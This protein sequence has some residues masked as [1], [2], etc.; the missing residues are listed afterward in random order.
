MDD[1]IYIYL[2][3]SHFFC[4]IKREEVS[5]VELFLTLLFVCPML[6]LAGLIDGITGGGGII[7]LPTYILTG[8]P[9]N[10]AYGCNKM[11]SFFGTS[12][13][14]LKY[15][16]NDLVDFRP[17]VIACTTA[18]LGS[19]LSTQIMMGLDDGVKKIII[20]GA[21]A[22]IICLTLLTTRYHPHN[23]EQKKM[24]LTPAKVLLC[25]VCG[26]ALGLYDGFF[27]PGGGTVALMLFTVLFGYDMR[28]ATGNGKL[29]IVVSNLIA[30]I[31]YVAKGSIMYEIAIPAS[32]ANILGSYIGAHLAIK[33]GKKLVQWVLYA[34]IVVLIGQ[35]VLKLV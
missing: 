12:A 21:M 4:I 6:F 31:S 15:A 20:A 22:F 2:I 7:S 19:T 14:L 11:Q 10:V 25:L 27:G 35:S 5:F 13:S 33:K 34:V 9:L 24:S 17:A 30:L 29:I 23:K 8:M 1:I 16:K 18:I 3:I 32:I 26:L 28:V